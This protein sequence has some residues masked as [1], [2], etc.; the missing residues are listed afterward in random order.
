MCPREKRLLAWQR[1]AQDLDLEKLGVIAH[2]ITLGEAIPTAE[3]LLDG[4][5]RGRVIVDVTK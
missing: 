2:Q 3:K 4:K 1:L 5:V